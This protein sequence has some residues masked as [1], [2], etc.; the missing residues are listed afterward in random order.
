MNFCCAFRYINAATLSKNVIIMLDMSGSM[1]GQRFE[2]AKQTVEAILETLS[3]NDFFNI[4]L[5]ST[6]SDRLRQRLNLRSDFYMGNFFMPLFLMIKL[7]SCSFQKRLVFWMNVVKKL[8]YC[9]QQFAIRRYFFCAF[10][11]FLSISFNCF[12]IFN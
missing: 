12:F 6:F 8:G 10:S 3:D 2:I 9:K 1:L 5:V 7:L 4:L 11:F